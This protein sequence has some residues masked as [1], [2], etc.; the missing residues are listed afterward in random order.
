MNGA[1]GSEF[2]W[3]DPQKRTVKLPAPQY[4]DYVMSWIQNL[5]DDESVFPTKTGRDFP[6]ES[7]HI[8]KQIHRQ[9]YRVF[10]HIY[11][12]HYDMMLHLR[13]E[14][15]FNSLF[16]HFVAFSKEFNL[17]DVKEMKDMADLITEM[18]AAGR[19]G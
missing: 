19:L 14:G 6:K 17:M 10:A 11:W 3:T 9:L 7:V 1:P 12:N 5:L 13:Q 15:H 4:I 16:A 2:T 8:I 18:E